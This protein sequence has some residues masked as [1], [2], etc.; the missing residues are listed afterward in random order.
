MLQKLVDF[1]RESDSERSL[2]KVYICQSFDQKS[3]VLFFLTH[4]V[5][6]KSI[7]LKTSNK[8]QPDTYGV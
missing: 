5:E 8:C 7:A 4:T 3:R 6:V 1:S 2:K